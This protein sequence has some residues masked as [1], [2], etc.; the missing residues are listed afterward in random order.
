MEVIRYCGFQSNRSNLI[1]INQVLP[2]LTFYK[3]NM[4]V[5]GTESL[6]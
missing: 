5:H 1:A 6:L 3:H 4:Y 2:F